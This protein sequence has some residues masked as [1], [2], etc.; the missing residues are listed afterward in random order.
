MSMNG[1]FWMLVLLYVYACLTCFAA[2]FHFIRIRKSTFS[3]AVILLIPAMLVV[4]HLFSGLRPADYSA[5]QH[6]YYEAF[7]MQSWAIF[8]IFTFL[9]T[10]LWW[11]DTYLWHQVKS[12]K[13][14]VTNKKMPGKLQTK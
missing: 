10:I 1:P 9:V 8:V 4:Q 3:A 7:Q 14:S 5:L 12:R 11:L 6:I 13:K 2:L